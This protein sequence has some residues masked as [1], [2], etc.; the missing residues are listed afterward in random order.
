MFAVTKFIVQHSN[1]SFNFIH[2]SPYDDAG[3]ENFNLSDSLSVSTGQIDRFDQIG[4]TTSAIS[5]LVDRRCT[6][7][8]NHYLNR[9]RLTC[10]R[11]P[12]LS[13]KW[14]HRKRMWTVSA[15]PRWGRSWHLT[16]G[17]RSHP[18]SRV[19]DTSIGPGASKTFRRSIGKH[20]LV[21]VCVC[22]R[23]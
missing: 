7:D 3:T 14:R 18:D 4:E 20:P 2:S 11:S 15:G 13:R 19:R 1:R 8:G 16:L 12:G 23:V 9:A 10:L 17:A 6:L 22:G 5:L 21:C